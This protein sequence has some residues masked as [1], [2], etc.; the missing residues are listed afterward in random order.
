MNESYKVDLVTEL[1][2]LGN[3]LRKVASGLIPNSNKY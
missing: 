3:G 1:E 2:E